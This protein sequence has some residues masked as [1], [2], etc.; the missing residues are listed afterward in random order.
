[1]GGSEA[2]DVDNCT[3]PHLLAVEFKDA[4]R[5][6]EDFLS[7]ILAYSYRCAISGLGQS[8]CFTQA[9]GP[10]LHPCQIVPQDHYHRYPSPLQRWERFFAD[11]PNP[12]PPQVSLESWSASNGILLMSHLREV[13]WLGWCRFT[14]RHYVYERFSL[15]C[16]HSIRRTEGFCSRY[17]GSRCA[18]TSP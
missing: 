7:I 8:W 12:G 14:P 17:C 16:Y 4:E 1:M 13:F 18:Q 9:I 2:E 15:W 10:A 5:I 3:V 11:D 6:K